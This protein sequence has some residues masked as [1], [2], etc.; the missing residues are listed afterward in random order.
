[1]KKE[2]TQKV[3]EKGMKKGKER[4]NWSKNIFLCRT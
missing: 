2:M 1:M 4:N 3:R